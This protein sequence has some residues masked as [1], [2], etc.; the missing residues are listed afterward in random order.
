[1]D[2]QLH[3]A[4]VDGFTGAVNDPDGTAY[5]AFRDFPLAQHPVMGKTGTAEVVMN[6]AGDLS[7][8]SVFVGMVT[9]ANGHP[10]VVVSLVEQAGF[11]AAISAPIVKRVMQSLIGVANPPPL[12]SS[13][14]GND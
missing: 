9:G 12:A 8:T 2:P 5:D 3:S 11:G 13:A 6:K 1:M 4:L 14:T 10:Y 7:D